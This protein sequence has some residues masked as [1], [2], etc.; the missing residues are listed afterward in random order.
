VQ[1]LLQQRPSTQKPL[2]HWLVP[3]QVAPLL[4]FEAQVWLAVQ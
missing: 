3:V 1:S 4:S 2:L